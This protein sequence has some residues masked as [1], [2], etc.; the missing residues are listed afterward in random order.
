MTSRFLVAVIAVIAIG[1]AAARIQRAVAQTWFLVR[2][3]RFLTGE[4]HHGHQVTDAGWLRHG[5]KAL[6]RTGHAPRWW[7][8]PRW[9]RT[10]HR[11]GGV[12]AVL[13]VLFSWL[14]DP[15]ATQRQLAVLAAAGLALGYLR[16]AQRVRGRRQKR[17]WLY[18]LHL[19]AHEIAG[20][21][22]A[23]RAADWIRAELDDAG[24]VRRAT[25][26]LPQGWPADEKDKQ[27]LVSTAAAKLGIE[28]AEPS[29]RLAGPAPLL[30][31]THSPP[32]PGHV[33]LADLIEEMGKCKDDEVVIGVGKNDSIV[34]A[35][36]GTDSPH[37]ALSMGTGA[38]K[39]NLAGFILLQMLVRGSIGLVLDAKRRLSYPW[40]LKDGDRNVVQLPNIAYAWTTPQMHDAM[41]WLPE[42]L[43]R[44][45]DVAFTAMDT[46]G[47]VHANVGARLFI[48]A[49]ELNLAIPR[50]RA[51]WQEIRGGDGPSKSP[52]FT[53]LGETAFAGRQVRK[54]LIL[55]G[56]MLTAE[57]TGSRDSSVKENCGIKL[58]ARY[59]P[60]GWRMMAE[61]IPMPPPPTVLGRVQV[62]TGGK[63]REA[64]VPEMDEV[65]ARQM[66]LDGVISPLPHDMPCRP[67]LPV[68]PAPE[69]EGAPDQHPETAIPVSPVPGPGLVT[70]REAVRLGVVHP[71][72]T[73]P[74]LR[75]ARFRDADFPVRRELRGAEH[76]YAAAELAAYDLARRS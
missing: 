9:Q 69:L 35:S 19:A 18:P 22:A 61:D 8:L 74:S 70:L 45:G 29:W 58:L 68:S 40:L 13:L 43:N 73:L 23:A 32:P 27:R 30:T 48:L 64:Q 76:L 53:G 10:L 26:A 42:E 37:I 41:A 24:A 6:T 12:A 17:T 49:E 63:A 60:K 38:G 71:A 44:R 14:A 21:P 7:Y 67:R 4:A 46:R 20:I 2:A 66:V 3:W 50:L 31:L 28:S 47:K 55:V 52:A 56:Q 72:T 16:A 51:H 15:V 5:K 11:S 34:R 65:A 54:H 59:G 75:M 57:A 39:S 33:K 1:Y 25:L 36:L 62:V